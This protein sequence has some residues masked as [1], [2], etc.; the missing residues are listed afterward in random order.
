MPTAKNLTTAKLQSL[1]KKGTKF[2]EREAAF[3]KTQEKAL[4]KFETSLAKEKG[5]LPTE[6]KKLLSA[7]L[8]NKRTPLLD[9]WK[10]FAA[11]PE[12]FK[13]HSFYIPELGPEFD[14]FVKRHILPYGR[15]I[16][17]NMT[18]WGNEFIFNYVEDGDDSF[19]EWDQDDT[20][21]NAA[22]LE[23]I[24]AHNLGSFCYDW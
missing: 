22:L 20:L 4:K 1:I 13:N 21:T 23:D 3:I 5:S 19:L 18:E 16:V 11:A 2:D 7:F 12:S 14:S 24:L 15:G 10:M 8:K 9:R 17:V 6:G